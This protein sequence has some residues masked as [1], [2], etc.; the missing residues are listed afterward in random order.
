[1]FDTDKIYNSLEEAINTEAELMHEHQKHVSASTFKKAISLGYKTPGST[2]IVQIN[3]DG[4][5][6]SIM[7]HYDI[8]MINCNN[9][10]YYANN[11]CR[12][13]IKNV[14]IINCEDPCDYCKTLK[15]YDIDYNTIDD[16]YRKMKN[17]K[18]KEKY[19]IWKNLKR[20]LKKRSET[21]TNS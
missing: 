20:K 5:I 19:S 3:Y 13:G 6:R 15:K 7:L 11:K 21:K 8:N 16:I 2:T 18:T 1:M 14:N 4:I 12:L 10:E 9:C 17:P